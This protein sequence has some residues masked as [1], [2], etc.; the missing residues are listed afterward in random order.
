MLMMVVAFLCQYCLTLQ[1]P[2][3]HQSPSL[4]IML[5]STPKPRLLSSDVLHAWLIFW[6]LYMLILTLSAA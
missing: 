1:L 5:V 6:K 2:S 3:P 4:S